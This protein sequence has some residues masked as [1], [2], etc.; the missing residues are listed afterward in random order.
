L[1]IDGIKTKLYH[2]VKYLKYVGS[3]FIFL[4]LLIMPLF[5]NEPGGFNDEELSSFNSGASFVIK[6]GFMDVKNSL[7]GD[8]KGRYIL[9]SY[10]V[11][12]LDSNQYEVE[13]VFDKRKGSFGYSHTLTIYILDDGVRFWVKKDGKIYKYLWNQPSINIEKYPN[14]TTIKDYPKNLDVSFENIYLSFIR[15]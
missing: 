11:K 15:E 7:I 10:D 14:Q 8:A 9:K 13:I 3:V 2:K 4:S 12:S 6:E 1:V 5:A